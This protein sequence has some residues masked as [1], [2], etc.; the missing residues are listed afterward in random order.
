MLQP[1]Y[2]AVKYQIPQ[3]I[4]IY[5][6]STALR[7]VGLLW[8]LVVYLSATQT[9]L[10]LTV[11]KR[12]VFL[13]VW[14]RG[15]YYW[16]GEY[17]WLCC[18]WHSP[19]GCACTSILSSVKTLLF[20]WWR[21]WDSPQ[22]LVTHWSQSAREMSSL[23]YI[24][25]L[26]SQYKS[27]QHVISCIS[28]LTNNERTTFSCQNTPTLSAT[29]AMTV[30]RWDSTGRPCE[31]HLDDP[32]KLTWTTGWNPPGQLRESH[33][34]DPVKLT[35]TTGWNSPDRPGD[36]NLSDDSLRHKLSAMFVYKVI[37]SLVDDLLRTVIHR[38]HLSAQQQFHTTQLRT[39]L[40]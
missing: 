7:S 26:S 10:S 39:T 18:L 27:Q 15:P 40:Q 8:L 35:W 13:V 12:V 11:A 37:G 23:T 1:R 24:L 21:F 38:N 29:S 25:S 5:E 19:T 22:H 33:L 16:A 20:N 30:A 14:R 34:D 2:Q 6:T 36:T 28:S 17:G 3:R 4:Q 31:S 9:G 32:V